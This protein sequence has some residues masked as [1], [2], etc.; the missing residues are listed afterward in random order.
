[1]DFYSWVF[2]NLYPCKQSC[3]EYREGNVIFMN[4]IWCVSVRRVRGDKGLWCG[5]CRNWQALCNAEPAPW[6]PRLSTQ[7]FHSSH[8]WTE[9]MRSSSGSLSLTWGLSQSKKPWGSQ[10][11]PWSTLEF[12]SVLLRNIE[13]SSVL[14]FYCWA[15]YVAGGV[16]ALHE[17]M[18]CVL[19]MERFVVFICLFDFFFETVS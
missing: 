10:C 16:T 12:C 8:W 9:V 19:F 5:V 14:A 4:I 15:I 6:R 13:A 2:S 1:M 11:W 3:N 7:P 17:N 18:P